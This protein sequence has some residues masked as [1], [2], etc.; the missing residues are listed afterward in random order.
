MVDGRKIIGIFLQNLLEFLDGLVPAILVLFRGCARNVQAGICGAQIEARVQ[1]SGVR[2]LGLLEIFNGCIR[3]AVLKGIYALIEQVASLQ[4][5]AAGSCECENQDGGERGNPASTYL[6]RCM[7]HE[8]SI[9]TCAR[10]G[11]SR[12]AR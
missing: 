12:Y 6:K 9:P 10:P 5:V 7:S 8:A 4:L 11:L 1:K 3:L 2:F